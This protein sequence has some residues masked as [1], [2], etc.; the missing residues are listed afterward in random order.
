MKVTWGWLAD[1]VDL[2]P[3]PE[4]LAHDLAMR[5]FPVASIEQRVSLDPA[6]IVGRVL[7]A[8]PHPNADRLR[9]CV[10]DVGSA[11]LSIVCGAS[12]VAAGQLV[13]VAQI[14]S[15]LPD[16]TKLRKTKIRGVESEG[17]IC[18]EKELGLSEES[19]GIWVLPG[20]PTVGAPLSSAFGSSDPVI[21]VEI[22]ANRTDCMGVV[23]LAREVA[24]AR[25]KVLKPSAPLRAEGT[26]PLPDVTIESAKD[27]PRYM[28]RVV[29][30][31]KIGPSP[32]WL[33]RRLEAAG[34][35]SI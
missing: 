31:L 23:G 22:T 33:R 3:T 13:A 26:Q 27:C 32:E 2:P 14:G 28:A 5:G 4:A 34:F 21:D 18:S 12:N 35:L 17:M 20:D 16:G 29:T 9:L 30:G 6:I 8:S 1:W 15:R 19:Q 25:G 11:K 7:E 24:S 10:V